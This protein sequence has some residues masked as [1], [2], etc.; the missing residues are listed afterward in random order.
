MAGTGSSPT[1]STR[2]TSLTRSDASSSIRTP[3]GRWAC[4]PARRSSNRSALSGSPTGSRRPTAQSW[5]ART[6]LRNDS[7]GRPLSLV[8]PRG[9]RIFFVRISDDEMDP[10]EFVEQSE[11]LIGRFV[12]PARMGVDGA[13]N[14]EVRGEGVELEDRMVLA[15]DRPRDQEELVD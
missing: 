8:R 7:E 15:A 3:A 4:G 6:S 10:A 11:V 14:G 13:H 5:T 2:G 1:R 12:H 9:P